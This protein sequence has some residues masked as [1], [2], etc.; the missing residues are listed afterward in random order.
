[1]FDCAIW[2]SLLVLEALLYFLDSYIL[3]L[4]S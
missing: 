4:A 1:M 3:T 2:L